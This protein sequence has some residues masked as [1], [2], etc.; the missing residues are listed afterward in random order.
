MRLSK[1]VLQINWTRLRQ[2]LWDVI[3]DITR[4]SRQDDDDYSTVPQRAYDQVM[5]LE[6]KQKVT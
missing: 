4:Q 3:T 2:R 1:P 6:F 5:S